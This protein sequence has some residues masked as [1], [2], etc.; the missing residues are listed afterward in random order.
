[1]ATV[2]SG[3]ASATGFFEDDDVLEF[4]S[5]AGNQGPFT[6]S[7]GAIRGVPAG[8][9]PWVVDEGKAELEQDE[10]EIEVE[11]LVLDPDDDR[12]PADLQGINP[13]P[14]FKGV[15]S[16]LTFDDAG[17]RLTET[18]ETDPVEVGEDGDAKIEAEIDLPS[19]CYAP[20]VFVT[21]AAEGI[22]TVWFAVGGA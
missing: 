10:I 13:V 15:V 16:C 3:S 4:D 17:N 12:V 7:G 14:G 22:P 18:V 2:A 5:L 20:I 8:G 19:P 9:L 21:A 11:G 6:G 1:M